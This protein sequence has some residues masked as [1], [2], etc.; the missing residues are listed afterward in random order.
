MKKKTGNL[1]DVRKKSISS[2]REGSSV[3]LSGLADWWNSKWL[4]KGFT[5]T[6][7]CLYSIV[8]S[9]I[10]MANIGKWILPIGIIGIIVSL[11]SMVNEL[12][13]SKKD[14]DDLAEKVEFENQRIFDLE[15][16]NN[17]KDSIIADLT[18]ACIRYE[19][20]ATILKSVKS[21]YRKIDE[22]TYR[23][24]TE[25]LDKNQI[26]D[27]AIRNYIRTIRDPASRIADI[28]DSL[29]KCLSEISPL[30]HNDICFSAAISLDQKEWNEFVIE[31]IDMTPAP[32][33]LLQNNSLFK[34]V[35]TPGHKTFVYIP[36][37]SNS[38]KLPY[39]YDSVDETTGR[40]GSII[41]WRISL[42][43]KHKG[44]MI[45]SI[46]TYGEPLVSLFD[47]NVKGETIPTSTERL[48]EAYEG[49]IRDDILKPFAGML[50]E[51]LLWYVIQKKGN[52]L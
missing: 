18:N 10:A 44:S 26:T 20:E 17:E 29:A 36:D 27:E 6:F 25:N 52:L 50:R 45:I 22:T 41:C 32:T 31:P 11:F 39:Y 9:I 46:S 2:M 38:G 35:A 12:A 23:K 51:E 43:G 14:A 37:K 1:I 19:S 34:L 28:F 24:L 21:A 3:F 8:L 49:R 42:T 40:K 30:D 7:V 16:S 15:N 48:K 4:L 13:T 5:K 33:E 47:K